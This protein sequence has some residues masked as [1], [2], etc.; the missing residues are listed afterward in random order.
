MTLIGNDSGGAYSQIALTRHAIA[1]PSGSCGLA[2]NACETPYDPFPPPPSTGYPPWPPTLPP[3][4]GARRPRQ[5]RP[6]AL[7]R[8]LG[9]LVKTRS[10]PRSPIP[11]RC[12]P[13]K[14]PP[15]C[16]TRK[17]DGRAPPPSRLAMPA[18]ALIEGSDPDGA[19]LV[20]AEDQ[21]FPIAHAQRYAEALPT[22][23]LIEI[24]DSYSFTPE[25]RPDALAAAIRSFAQPK[26]GSANE[27]RDVQ[28]G[29]DVVRRSGFG[30]RGG[31]TWS[32][33]CASRSRPI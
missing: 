11:M 25:D 32:G 33:R 12:L 17:G 18:N 19:D 13:R 9:L 31:R 24:E 27:G 10:S 4:G 6:S 29:V 21:V 5:I 7:R 23:S 8:R 3:R 16:P 2:L 14:T 26:L 20:L 30:G 28:C 15:S 1:S 22:P